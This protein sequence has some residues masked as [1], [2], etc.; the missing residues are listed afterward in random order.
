MTAE[1][2]GGA[3]ARPPYQVRVRWSRPG[4]YNEEDTYYEVRYI[5]EGDTQWSVKQANATE[6]ILDG[7]CEFLSSSLILR[8]IHTNSRTPPARACRVHARRRAL[9]VDSARAHQPVISRYALEACARARTA[10]T[11]TRNTLPSRS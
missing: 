6:L 2:V 7:L 1:L 3:N 10:F 4:D 11:T 5:A 9:P 8:A